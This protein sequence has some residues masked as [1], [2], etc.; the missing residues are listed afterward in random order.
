MIRKSAGICAALLSALWLVG[1]GTIDRPADGLIRLDAQTWRPTEDPRIRAGDAARIEALTGEIG[2][3]LW[4]SPE[5]GSILALSG[6][7]ANGAYGAGVLVGWTEAG[8]RPPFQ[9]VTGV[10]TGALAAPFAFLGPEWDDELRATYTGGRTG[11]LLSWRSFAALVAPGLFSPGALEHLVEDYFTPELL[12]RIAIEHDKGRRLLIV[13]TNLDTQETV[14]WDMGVLAKQGGDQA[15]VLFREVLIASASIPGVF[16]PVMIPGVD[17]QGRLVE[18]MHVDGGVNTPFLGIPESMLTATA[19]T[20]APAGTALYVLINGQV[21]RNT[22]ITRGTLPAILA[23][24]YDTMGK[25]SLR[26]SLVVNQAFAER[27]GIEMH[28][29]AIPDE[30]QASSLDFDRESM[31]GLF[32]QGRTAALGGQAWSRLEGAETLPSESVEPEPEP[33]PVALPEPPPAD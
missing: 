19:P 9:V 33:E 23:R 15:L 16:P 12:R 8:T 4:T 7:G 10:S 32:E 11:G 30:V 2:E 1:C 14:I 13:T 21:G 27:N 6:G 31:A 26:T 25:A 24:T 17:D 29:A 20:R 3:R 5:P 28:I 18:E 22:R